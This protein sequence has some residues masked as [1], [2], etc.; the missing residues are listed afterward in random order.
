MTKLSAN[1][2]AEIE[3]IF[4]KPLYSLRIPFSQCKE[5]LVH[6]VGCHFEVKFFRIEQSK[7]LTNFINDAIKF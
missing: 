3:I 5:K 6:F 2:T 4:F 7:L 1:R